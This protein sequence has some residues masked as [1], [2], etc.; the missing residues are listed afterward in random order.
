MGEK[1][2]FYKELPEA[3]KQ[4]AGLEPLPVGTTNPQL[5]SSFIHSCVEKKK[6]DEGVERQLQ[7]QV[8]LLD[9][10]Q[11][12]HKE[13][14]K[15]SLLI[16]Q[17]CRRLNAKQKRQLKLFEIPKEEQKYSLYLP[18][19]SLWVNY[20]EDL[21]QLN[22]NKPTTNTNN[23]NQKV[24]KADFHGCAMTVC[25]SKCKSYVG[26]HGI[27]IQE[28][29]NTFRLI[30]KDD[31]IRTI[32]KANSLFSFTIKDVL[33]TL[34]GSHLKFRPGERSARKFKEK[35]LTAKDLDYK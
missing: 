28:T 22:V 17:R 23:L 34:R 4:D 29:Q 1:D 12:P 6:V 20:M 10:P 14:K 18:L 26:L 32:P 9:P 24:L 33:F 2:E 7:T 27:M 11:R 15:S 16:P 21:L 8:I 35:P 31:K 13:E 5:I 19:H 3:V 30:C 25:R